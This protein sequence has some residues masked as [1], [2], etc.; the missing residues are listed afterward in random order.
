MQQPLIA[1]LDLDADNN[2]EMVLLSS[3]DDFGSVELLVA[4]IDPVA[5]KATLLNKKPLVLPKTRLVTPAISPLVGPM[6]NLEELH[7]RLSVC[8]LGARLPAA[9]VTLVLELETSAA[10]TAVYVLWADDIKEQVVAGAFPTPTVLRPPDKEM[11]VGFGC[12]NADADEEREL[13]M[14]TLPLG[15][16]GNATIYAVELVEEKRE[17]AAPRVLAELGAAPKASGL[18]FHG[19]ITADLTADGV[20]DLVVAAT[21]SIVVLPGV[22]TLP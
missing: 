1:P 11:I 4:E 16:T 5:A 10:P 15:G 2:D 7:N 17:F 13:A 6:D 18:P 20:D 9:L 22:P 12:I 8:K 21:G 3:S 19:L 14:I